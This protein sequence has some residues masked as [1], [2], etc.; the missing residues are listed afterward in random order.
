MLS[1]FGQVAVTRSVA[2]ARAA[3][4]NFHRHTATSSSTAVASGNSEDMSQPNDSDT[5]KKVADLN[6]KKKTMA[7][8]DEEM[9]L[10]MEGIAGDG[11]EA[12]AELEDGKPVA[13]KRSVKENMFRYI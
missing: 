11:G 1:R 9:R 3:C 4:V 13:M 7:Q 8:L 12:G 6:K 2:P 10:A 5:D